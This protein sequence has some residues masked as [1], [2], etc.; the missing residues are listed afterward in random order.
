[1]FLLRVPAD[2]LHVITSSFWIEFFD[3]RFF[4]FFVMHGYRKHLESASGSGH[5][6]HEY[7]EQDHKP[8]RHP[9]SVRAQPLVSFDSVLET[10]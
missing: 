7:P 8:L 6:G 3:N 2:W 5:S 4:F 9:Q 10:D 1:M